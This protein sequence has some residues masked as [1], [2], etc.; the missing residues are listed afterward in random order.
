MHKKRGGIISKVVDRLDRRRKTPM[1]VVLTLKM[2]FGQAP[3]DAVTVIDGR[4]VPLVGSVF[5]NRDR[6]AREFLRLMVKV[7]ARQPRI[8]RTLLGRGRGGRD[9]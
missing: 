9:S 3:G 5:D 6:I 8:V 7:G 1:E 2:N 4:R